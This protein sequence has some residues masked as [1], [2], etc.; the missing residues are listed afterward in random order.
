M[1]ILHVYKDYHPVMGGIENH[2]RAVAR[3]QA[4][5]GHDVTVLVTNPAG[6]KTSVREEEGVRVIRASR[7]ATIA[8]TPLSIELFRQLQ[9]QSPDVTHLHFPYPL[10]EVSQWLLRRGRVTVL[11]YHSDVIKQAGILKLYNPLLKRILRSVDRIIATSEPYIHS[12][13]YLR[14]VADRCTV[15]PLGIDL[16]RFAQPQPRNVEVIRARHPGPLL[17]F[18]GRLRYYKGLNYLIEAMKQIEATLLIV[19]TGPEAADLGEQ[20]YLAGV[21]DKV[22]FLGDISDEHLPAYFQSADLFVLPSSQRSEAFGIVLLEAMAAGTALIS[23][24]LST[25]TSWVNQHDRTGLVIPP[26]D[27]DA[28][29]QA[30]NSLLADDARRQQMGANAQHRARTEFGLPLLV[31]RLLALYRDVVG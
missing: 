8:S 26:R 2:L 4:E 31:D 6:R 30:I 16:D 3:T 28:L 5:R 23:T 7:L 21:A 15:I 22:R 10:G 18:V 9:G 1:R 11:T 14:P 19:G 29:A 24:E 13:P 20:A 17:L 25:G 12:S 27:P